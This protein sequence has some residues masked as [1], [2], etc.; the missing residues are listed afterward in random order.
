MSK[1]FYEEQYLDAS[2]PGSFS[3]LESFYRALKARGQ[4]VK[5]K[6]LKTW[7][8]GQTAY[9]L[10]KTARRKFKRNKVFSQGIDHIWQIDLVDMRNISGSNNRYNYMLTCIDVFSKFAW[11]VP[12]LKKTGISVENALKEIFSQGRIPKKIQSDEGKEFLNKNVKALLSKHQIEL[13]ILDSEMKASVIERFNRTLKEKMYRYFTANRVKRY[14]N[15]IQDIVHSYNHSFHRSIKTIPANITVMNEE[16]IR[17]I[18]YKEDFN[19]HNNYDFRFKFRIG[20][21]VRISKHKKIFHKGYTP[22]WSD[23]IF[24][25]VERHPRVPPVYTIKDSENA[26]VEGVFYEPELQKIRI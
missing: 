22:N 24:Q 10:H 7:M 20:D 2:K 18:L 14:L 25:I 6:E 3:G 13:Y 19:I 1:N 9:T 16:S 5:K 8:E 23:E 4:P 12:M 15:V 21:I 17:K 11:V 26:I